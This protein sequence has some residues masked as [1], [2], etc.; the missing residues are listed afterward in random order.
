MGSMI[1]AVAEL[2]MELAAVNR[3]HWHIWLKFWFQE[4]EERLFAENIPW[5]GR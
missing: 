2:W 4:K 1:S 3:T 5:R